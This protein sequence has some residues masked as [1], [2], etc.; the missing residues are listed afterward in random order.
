MRVRREDEDFLFVYFFSLFV[1][2]LGWVSSFLEN[3][4]LI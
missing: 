2:S 1:L 4:S 3:V